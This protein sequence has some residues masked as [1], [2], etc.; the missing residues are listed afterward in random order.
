MRARLVTWGRA[1]TALLA[2]A[3]GSVLACGGGG[4]G[5]PGLVTTTPTWI[6]ASW[7]GGALGQ[8]NDY[9]AIEATEWNGQICPAN[10]L[11]LD[12]N[13][14][15]LNYKNHCTITVTYA[16]CVAKGTLQGANVC[17][18]DPLNT[19][20]SNLL[21]RT[22]NPG[23]LGDYI[24]ASGNLGVNIFYCSDQQQLIGGPVRCIGG[25]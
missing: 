10:H 17:S 6:S 13:G 24:N 21:F 19:S 18:P 14:T 1:R 20:T 4:G 7:S 16:I 8:P 3:V 2:L 25:P 5:V 15:V 12:Y 23:N 9:R 11:E 22:V